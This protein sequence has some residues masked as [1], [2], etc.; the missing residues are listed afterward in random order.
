[1]EILGFEV[2]AHPIVVQSIREYESNLHCSRRFGEAPRVFLMVMNGEET[3]LLPIT[4][5]VSYTQA[6]CVLQRNALPV[7]MPTP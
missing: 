6:I 7:L 4:P 3:D 1:M 5:F 2:Q